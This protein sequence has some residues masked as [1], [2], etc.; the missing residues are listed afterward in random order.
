[1]AKRNMAFDGGGPP[2]KKAPKGKKSPPFASASEMPTEAP[3]YA[4]GG[5]VKTK[6]TGAQPPREGIQVVDGYLYVCLKLATTPKKSTSGKTF[7]VASTHGNADA[8]GQYNRRT[9]KVGVNAF[10]K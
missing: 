9:V 6:G 4:E 10:Y 3:A 1:M 2:V 7:I 8:E 5:L